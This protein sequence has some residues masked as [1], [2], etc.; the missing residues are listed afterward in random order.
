M[1]RIS[2][3]EETPTSIKLKIEGKLIGD[4]VLLLESECSHCLTGKREVQL[5]FA[6]VTFVDGTVA[7]TLSRLMTRNVKVVSSNP[8]VRELLKGRGHNE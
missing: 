4:W 1:L 7:D 3:V 8:L 2:K 6:D 5:D